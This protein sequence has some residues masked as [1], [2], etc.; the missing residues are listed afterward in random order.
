MK[1]FLFFNKE[2][3]FGRIS[4]YRL[5][6]A[7]TQ[8]RFSLRSQSPSIGIRYFRLVVELIKSEN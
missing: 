5:L 8:I 1:P 2:M 7:G 6:Q 3:Q 4:S